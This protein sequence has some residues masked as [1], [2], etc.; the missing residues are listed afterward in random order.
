MRRA[1]NEGGR[2]SDGSRRSRKM[3]AV[4]A[5]LAQLMLDRAVNVT[6]KSSPLTKSI[7]W[8]LCAT[9]VKSLGL[10]DT[11]VNYEVHGHKIRLPADSDLPSVLS[12]CPKY[13]RNLQQI[14]EAVSSKY[15][16]AQMID[17][18]ANVG[19]TAITMRASADGPLLC[20]EASRRYAA[21]CR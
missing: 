15:P 7:I 9:A 21:L 17:I 4:R 16:H 6:A 14:A 19:D 8:R 1:E 13:G 10:L 12:R 11:L 5:A 2:R 18:G 3:P 20:V